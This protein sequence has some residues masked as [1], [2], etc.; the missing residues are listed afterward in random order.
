MTMKLRNI[1]GLMVI[2]FTALFVQSCGDDADGQGKEATGLS[3][4]RNGMAIETLNFNTTAAYQMLGIATDGNWTASV[5]DADTTWLKITPHA[6]YG[7]NY[8]DSGAVNTNAYIRVDAM[9]NSGAER[10]STITI[11]AGAFSK[12]ITVTQSGRG[13]AG[14]EPIESAWD[15]IAKLK[16]GYNLGN[17][18][19]SEPSGDWWNPV[20]KTPA[21]FETSWGQPVTTQAIIDA[22]C[23]QGFNIIRV[24]VTWG[25]H[26][27]ADNKI[28]EAWM[29][30]VEEVV[31]YVMNRKDV[32]CII[33][34]MHD[35]GT[36]SWLYADLD[37]YP[38]QTKKYQAIWKQIAE[39]FKK[40]DQ[41]LI[42]ESFNEILDKNSSWTTPAAGSAAYEAI[43]KLQQDFVNTVRATGGNNEYR[44]LAVTTYAATGNSANALNALKVPTDKHANHIY[45][46]IH[47]YDPYNFCNN[48]AGKN[49][50]GST[51]DYNITTF[52]DDCKAE[53]D[54]IFAQVNARFADL[55]I[56]Y[57]YGEFGAID[58][59]KNMD[60]RVKYAT[61]V[62]QKM[63]S[64]NT[65]GLW[66]MGL[67]KRDTKE[68]YEQRIVN[69]LKTGFGL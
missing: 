51:F 46:T 66:W 63:K 35:T 67:Y 34:V 45:G 39:R 37:A 49:A 65:T 23:D 18:L 60:E 3:V 62:A 43:N 44:N 28:D 48:N 57:I 16:M 31:N 9:T 1:F 8:A 4:L 50:D 32:Y 55:G 27:S 36:N 20:G 15:M 41:R 42:F 53:I 24:P 26:M 14:N 58:E 40:Y 61:Y 33:N 19:E 29:K 54:R 13:S 17:T 11:T 59:N 69:A 5:P 2:L 10:K 68:W 38:E 21:D 47:S 7:W 52:N 64:Y 12:V 30:R 25:N 56:P 6:G 22:I